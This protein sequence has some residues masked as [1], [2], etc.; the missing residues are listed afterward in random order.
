MNWQA[1]FSIVYGFISG[2]GGWRAGGWVCGWEGGDSP[3]APCTEEASGFGM[4]AAVSVYWEFTAGFN[5]AE[6]RDQREKH[7]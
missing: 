7:A 6:R 5:A 1:V 2:D 3:P 4:K